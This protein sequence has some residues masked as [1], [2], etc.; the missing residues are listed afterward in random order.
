MTGPDLD[1]AMVAS[2]DPGIDTYEEVTSGGTGPIW[3]LASQF[4]ARGHE[5]TIYSG[6][7]GARDRWS[8]AGVEIVEVPTPKLADGIDSL[9]GKLPF[10]RRMTRKEKLSTT[11]GEM[12]ERLFGRLLFARR[13]AKALEQAQPDLVYLRDRISA[14]WPVRTSPASV[15]TVTSPDA[16]DFYYDAAVSRHPIN[17]LLFAYK[18]RV[19][20]SVL[21]SADQVVTMNDATKRHLEESGFRNATTVTLGVDEE[22]FADLESRHEKPHVLYVGRLDGNKRPEWVL[23]AFLRAETD[24][25]ELHFAGSGPRRELL[26][27][28]IAESDRADDV[29]LLGRI[30]RREVLERMR[31]AAVFVLPSTFENCP[32]VIVEA[33]ASGCPVVASDT[34]G[35][36]ELLTDGETGLLFDGDDESAL[37]DALDR[38]LHHEGL[39]RELSRAAHERARE[40]HTAGRIAERYLAI[41]RRALGASDPSA[42]GNGSTRGRE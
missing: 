28:R 32:N 4:V 25:F 23:D 36:K 21:A 13:V 9:V 7:H 19:E 29:R 38:L 16:R 41:G 26:E 40:T 31:E 33:M 34:M 6:T 15:F 14:L 35:A 37:R 2:G 1:V 17:R 3:R 20:R 42:R 24:G 18:R 30:P 27:R 10:S 12:V 11:P 39:R 8:K 5:V 22:D